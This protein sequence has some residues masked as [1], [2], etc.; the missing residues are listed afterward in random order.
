MEEGNI[1]IGEIV[2]APWNARGEI[3]PESVADLAASI[4][5]TGLIN[6]ITLWRDEEA[7]ITYC[8]A[9]N[10][11][12]AALKSLG[13][14]EV[15]NSDWCEIYGGI[16]DAKLLT[17]AENLLREN[18]GMIEESEA[19]VDALASG[20]DV[21][22][23]SAKTGHTERWV[24]SRLKLSD[25]S[26]SWREYAKS[27]PKGVSQD[28]LVHAATYT[29]EIQERAFAK[30]NRGYLGNHAKW[31]SVGCLFD[32]ETMDLD[33]SPFSCSADACAKCNACAKRTGAQA[34]LFGEVDGSLGR[35]MDRKCY[36][37]TNDAYVQAQIDKV[38]KPGT[39]VVR[40]N[41]YWDV[42]NEANGT[43]QSTRKP[44]AYV[45]VHGR[46]IDIKFGPSRK[47]IEEAKEKKRAEMAEQR[48]EESAKCDRNRKVCN[49]VREAVVDDDKRS[50]IEKSVGD[51]VDNLED[52]DDGRETLIGIVLE[53]MGGYKNAEEVADVLRRFPAVADIAGI[54]KEETDLFI[55]ENTADEDDGED[56]CE[57]DE[58][59]DVDEAGEDE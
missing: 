20:L 18:I 43:K 38:A 14:K 53:W 22:D 57:G 15:A 30:A 35:C 34:D 2:L 16:K 11:R 59:G 41:G 26:S 31:A 3:T 28:A 52:L 46:T 12:L 58:D 1:K 47:A 19:M 27:N 25:L 48:A 55:A 39:E 21:K 23:L 7:G 5:E 9:G 44:C 4:K 54:G 51:F 29:P 36:K 42:P 17:I 56:E 37:A 49:A 24:K 40:V 32:A 10:R 6:P 8:I 50:E 33:D 45:L 13:L